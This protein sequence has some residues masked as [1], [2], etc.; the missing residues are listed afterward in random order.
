L[1]TE[2]KSQTRVTPGQRASNPTAAAVSRP[3]LSGVNSGALNMLPKAI[4]SRNRFQAPCQPPQSLANARSDP[5]SGHDAPSARRLESR[6]RLLR[7]AVA[8][9][10]PP[11]SAEPGNQD[12][13]RWA[14]RAWRH[15]TRFA[16]D[17]EVRRSAGNQSIS[18]PSPRLRSPDGR[19]CAWAPTA[20]QKAA[21]NATNPP[22][23]RCAP[24]HS[25]RACS[26]SPA[27]SANSG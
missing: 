24:R 5:N 11:G 3:T 10:G 2:P 16:L 23:Y 19:A 8:F 9:P 14:G 18:T 1:A 21:T 15:L 6:T 7:L 27:P 13:V 20:R 4:R 25:A 17:G 12:F 26:R 22:G